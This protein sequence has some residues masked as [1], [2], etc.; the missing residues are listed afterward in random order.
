MSGGSQLSRLRDRRPTVTQVEPVIPV[1]LGCHGA[2]ICVVGV[3][4]A[5]T[6][7]PFLL[8]IVLGIAGLLGWS[9]DGARLVRALVC[10]GA[11]LSLS[12]LEPVL[13]PSLLQWYYCVAAVYSLVLV[14]RAAAAV[15]PLTG[16]CYLAQVAML[17]GRVPAEVALLRAGVLS[18]LG[19]ATWTAGV[20]YRAAAR[21]AEAG[22][23]AA[24]LAGLE[25]IHA[26]T[27]DELTTLPNR[28]LLHQRL[29]AAME[30]GTP[31]ALL[32]MDLDG[33]KEVNDT[34]GHRYGDALLLQ[35]GERLASV[36]RPTET[37]ARL[38]GDEFA[39]LL[40]WGDLA[41]ANQ[42]AERLRDALQEPFLVEEALI[43]IDASVGIALAPLHAVDG[44]RLLQLADVAM[45]DAKAS[46]D[47]STVYDAA[48]E[49]HTADRLVLLAELRGA[50]TRGELVV[51]YQP[52]ISAAGG[53]SVGM[54]ALVRWDH[55]VRGRIMPD[56]FIPLAE[57]SGFIRPLT[58]FVL[59]AA[60]G[61]C[62]IWRDAG[63]G[64]TV[65]VNL[66]A[67]NLQQDD[68]PEQVRAALARH[69]LTPAFLELEITESFLMTDP[70]RARTLLTELYELGVRLSIDDFGTGMSSLSYLKNLPVEVLK[71]DKS[72]ITHML[73][74]AT[75]TLIV[76]GVINL[77]ASMGLQTV[78]EGVEDRA[79][80]TRLGEIGCTYAQGY[81]ISRPLPAHAVAAWCLLHREQS[82]E[83]LLNGQTV[84]VHHGALD[85]VATR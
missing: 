52:R 31:A 44:D 46:G 27:H 32:L 29:S 39:V 42:V 38:G 84:L 18:A 50:V 81:L 19:L 68:L 77:A 1:V 2:A 58:A 33:F 11:A 67:R 45:Y 55:P 34:L 43:A 53:H 63:L 28:A 23:R 24:E 17:S 79:T 47:G 62:R 75:D 5:W 3:G 51:E 64:L 40:P 57:R 59:D 21:D 10:T 12:V 60:L 8:V 78:A 69:G 61:Q 14:G 70:E 25:L 36:V 13:I 20:A 4:P 37:V 22:R 6:G 16:L 41:R 7:G 72:F 65:S 9:S 54:E 76:R 74:D 48:V 83:V 26:A 30:A 82:D 66:S 35:V 80:L 71:I 73:D 85:N 15:G 49:R 56:V